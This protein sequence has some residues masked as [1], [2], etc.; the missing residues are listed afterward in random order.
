MAIEIRNILHGRTLI[1]QILQRLIPINDASPHTICQDYR[2][3]QREGM[4]K[5][6]MEKAR[7]K[8]GRRGKKKRSI[9]AQQW[10]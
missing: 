9:C 10:I 1:L 4:E 5:G 6:K 2:D 8:S 3:A 7:E